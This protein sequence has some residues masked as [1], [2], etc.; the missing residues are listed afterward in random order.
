LD[1]QKF[2]I[3]QVGTFPLFKISPLIKNEAPYLALH[4]SIHHV[5]DDCGPTYIQNVT[6]SGKW[7]S[8]LIGDS[9]LA[10]RVVHWVPKTEALEVRIKDTWH[11]VKY[12]GKILSIVSKV[13]D[14][15]VNFVV[16]KISVHVSLGQNTRKVDTSQGYNFLN[17]NVEGINTHD[18]SQLLSGLL[19]R[20]DISGVETAPNNCQTKGK[21]FANVGISDEDDHPWKSFL[22][23][24]SLDGEEQKRT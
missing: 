15:R 19:I 1:G 6:L 5:Q 9:A 3:L 16:N 20:D 17:V 23:Y 21:G 13:T 22:S 11:P 24:A 14:S 4:A 10:V 7:L 18:R 12:A 2:N 8:P